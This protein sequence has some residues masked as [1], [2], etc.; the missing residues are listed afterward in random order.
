MYMCIHGTQEFDALAAYGV[1]VSSPFTNKVRSS[2]MLKGRKDCG[3]TPR[4]P[5]ALVIGLKP[6]ASPLV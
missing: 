4:A 5:L 6:N 3:M 2:S 1:V